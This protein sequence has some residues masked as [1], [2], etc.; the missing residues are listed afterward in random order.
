MTKNPFINALAAIAYIAGLMS[1]IFYSS[2][3]LAPFTLQLKQVPE[4]F[5][6]IT[7]LSL[8]VFSAATMGY[9]FL[10]N[11]ILLIL[12]GEKKEGTKLFLQTVGAFGAGAFLFVLIGLIL[13]ST[14]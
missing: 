1:L 6:G 2:T 11:P 9:F 8:F 14:F 10:Y 7:M 12:G 4:V 13:T 5:A 3:L